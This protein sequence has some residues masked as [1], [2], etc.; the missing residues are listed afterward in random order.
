VA[1]ECS[2]EIL[3]TQHSLIAIPASAFGSRRSDW[4]VASA[5]PVAG[6]SS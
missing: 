3:L 5:L 4:S 1:I 2:A 6:A